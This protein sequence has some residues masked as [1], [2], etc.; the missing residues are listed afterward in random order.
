MSKRAIPKIPQTGQD[1]EQFDSAV[2][3]NLEILM[4]RRGTPIAKLT[5]NETTAEIMLKLNEVIER[6]Q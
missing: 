3:E 4:G 6:L 5:G 2:K 1:R